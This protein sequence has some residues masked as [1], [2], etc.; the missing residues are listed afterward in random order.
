MQIVIVVLLVVLITVVGFVALKLL[1]QSGATT[2]IA[3]PLDT[4]LIVQSVQAAINIDSIASGV[5]TA[6]EAEML[7]TAAAALAINNTQAAQTLKTQT[8]ALDVQTKRL[9]QPFE[10]AM[11]QL[12]LTVGELKKT[13]ATEQGTIIALAQQMVTLQDTTTSLGNALKSPTARGSWGENQLRNVIRLAGMESYCDYSEQFTGGEGE[14]NQ[15]PD[16]VINLPTGGRIAID[17]KAPLA[18]YLRMQE[19]ADVATKEAELKQHAKDLRLHVKTLADKKYW[20]LFG[21]DT[22]DFVVMFIP[23]E[24]FVAD[25]MK[26][27]TALLDDAMKQRV[28]VASPMNLMALLLTVAKGWQSQKLAEHADQVAKLGSEMYERIGT[29]LDKMDKMGSGL[30]STNAAFNEMIGSVETRLLVTLR[31]FEKLG[32]AKGELRDVKHIEATPRV[33]NAP[34]ATQALG[35]GT[36]GELTELTDDQPE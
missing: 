21:H 11:T 8:E 13:Y 29:V 1:S 7:K 15:R 27:D 3:A 9:L 28:L 16:V 32:V 25:A 24:G 12:S 23:G 33:L 31:E 35:S 26:T 22:P 20:D 6:V 34:E 30:R 14:K 5:R 17:A 4:N 19:T 10:I 2:P 18:A 36:V